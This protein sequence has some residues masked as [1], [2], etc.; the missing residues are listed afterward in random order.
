MILYL[1]T[2]NQTGLKYLG[3]TSQA[4][5]RYNGSGHY[6]KRHLKK[7]GIDLTKEVLCES[8]DPAVIRAEGLRYSHHWD[9]IN[10]PTFANI[11]NEMGDGGDTSHTPAYIRNLKE[12]RKWPEE[13]KQRLR[14]YRK[15]N[16]RTP[17]SI[18]KQR[19]TMTGRPRG[20]YKYNHSNS[21]AVE[22]DG[23]VYPSLSQAMRAAGTTFR[24]HS[25]FKRLEPS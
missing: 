8:D 17:E 12:G 3:K 6:W 2:H 5:S 25:A 21:T 16:P 15:A 19:Q 11:R 7:H 18:E 1:F 20:P 4:L 10:N 24:N 13:S 23:K 14:D 22:Y 9:I